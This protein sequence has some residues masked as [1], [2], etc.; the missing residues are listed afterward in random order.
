MGQMFTRSLQLP[1]RQSTA[2]LVEL[3]TRIFPFL[4][5]RDLLASVPAVCR[6]WRA[7]FTNALDEQGR[8]RFL[9][10]SICNPS[11]WRPT[12]RTSRS[13]TT[14]PD[15]QVLEIM[16]WDALWQARRVPGITGHSSPGRVGDWK[17]WRAFFPSALLLPEG[18][19]GPLERL[20]RV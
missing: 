3:L 9:S 1:R 19:T 7:I 12:S 14:S 10:K 2:F 15:W 6:H 18:S 17:N 4:P 13:S 11:G 8:G 16:L 20:S 5:P